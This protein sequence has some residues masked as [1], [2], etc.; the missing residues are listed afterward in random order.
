MV[1]ES[2]AWMEGVLSI[3]TIAQRWR[4]TYLGT[5]PAHPASQDHTPVPCDLL[6]MRLTLR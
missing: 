6:L 5:T 3:A 4:M 2:F 1:G